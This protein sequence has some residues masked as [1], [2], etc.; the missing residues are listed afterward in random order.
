MKSIIDPKEARRFAAFLDERSRD[1]K[2][3]NS[4]VSQ[5]LLELRLGHWQDDKYRQFEQRFEEASVQLQIFLDHA[6][7]YAEYLRRKAEPIEK[8][9]D[10]RYR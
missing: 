5:Q 6:D 4:R 1:L 9:L 3:L 8:Y 10:R 2:A 7:K